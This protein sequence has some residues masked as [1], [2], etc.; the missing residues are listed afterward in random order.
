MSRSWRRCGRNYRASADFGD[1]LRA[2][3]QLVDVDAVV[4]RSER[5]QVSVRRELDHLD[6]LL[7][8]GVLDQRL[9]RQ[10]VED[11]PLAADCA[12]GDHVAGDREC[13]RLDLLA[14]VLAPDHRV[15]QRVPQLQQTIAAAGDELR[16]IRVDRQPPQFVRMAHYDWREAEI[17]GSGQNAVARRTDDE[18]RP[19]ALA[20]DPNAAEVVLDLVLDARR[21]HVGVEQN[22]SAVLAAAGDDAAVAQRAQTEYRAVVHFSAREK[23]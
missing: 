5:Q 3:A 11:Q 20:H 4:A 12:D 13:A 1:P 15:R 14:D 8:V 22:D 6:R 21:I 17:E 9:A 23:S 19:L 10:R 18:L 7:A 2:A 16:Q